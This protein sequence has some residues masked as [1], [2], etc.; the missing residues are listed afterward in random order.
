MTGETALSNAI[1]VR[2]LEPADVAE[3]QAMLAAAELPAAELGRPQARFIKLCRTDGG[4][5]G[6]AGLELHGADA[7]LRS[8]VVRPDRRGLG[9]GRLA[10]ETALARAE[11]SSVESVYLLT[12]TA[13]GFFT[14][15]GF[16]VVPRDRV[17]PA[18][19]RT[20]EFA[21]ICPT[22]AVCMRKDLR[23]PA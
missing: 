21:T 8:V 18:I 19:A 6:F 7:L 1:N 17:P 3:L 23:S 12:T 5:A 13:A 20:S 2:D 15:L 11:G 10:V 16:R 14:R 22:S 4:T 9:V